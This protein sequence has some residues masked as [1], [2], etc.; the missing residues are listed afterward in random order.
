MEKFTNNLADLGIWGRLEMIKLLKAIHNYRSN[1]VKEF[2]CDSYEI[3][4]CEDTGL[5]FVID[6]DGKKF[7]SENESLVLWDENKFHYEQFCDD[8]EAMELEEKGC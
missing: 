7:T 8:C 1:L 6:C 5:M 2:N 3:A 4:Y